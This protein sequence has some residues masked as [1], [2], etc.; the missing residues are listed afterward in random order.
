MRKIIHLDMDAFY[1]SIEQRDSPELRGKPVAVGGDG[2]RGVVASA[3]YEA[4]RQGVRSAMPGNRAK[5]LCPELIFVKPRFHVYREVSRVIQS[6]FYKY[7][8]FVEPLSLDEAYL[9]VTENKTG[10][11]SAL[12]LAYLIKEDIVKNTQLTASAGIAMNKFLAKV[13]S[14]LN[15]PNGCTFI[16]PEK[17]TQFIA[18][19]PIEKFFGIGESTAR[20]MQNLGIFN[21][22]DL[23]QFEKIDLIKKFGKHGHFFYDIA[24]GSDHRT[25]QVSQARKSLSVEKTFMED[26]S[27]VNILYKELSI[28]T[29]KMAELAIKNQ[30]TGH[31]IT[32]K[33][34]FADF[35][36]IT[37]QKSTQQPVNAFGEIYTYVLDLLNQHLEERPVRLLGV[38]ISNPPTSEQIQTKLPF[39]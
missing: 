22:E 29:N 33:I 16:A 12:K 32:L 7:T 21:G 20:K 13:A 37:R 17:A 27:D 4:R 23:R 15:K 5:Q 35:T 28:L 11:Q 10:I 2:P 31:T 19:L 9:D 38:G 26:I 36:T 39:Y 34:R 6:I 30:F 8:D 14:G 3:S 24:R 18:E 25:V 1:A